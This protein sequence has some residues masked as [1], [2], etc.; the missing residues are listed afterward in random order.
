[1]MK[2]QLRIF[3]TSKVISE[4]SHEGTPLR[5]WKVQLRSMN[6]S[7]HY[8]ESLIDHVEYRLHPSFKESCIIRVHEPYRIERTGWGEFDM[9]MLLYFRDQTIPPKSITFDLHFKRP[10]YSIQKTLDIPCQKTRPS[11]VNES[12]QRMPQADTWSPSVLYLDPF[13]ESMNIQQIK[14]D[15]NLSHLSHI[16]KSL[17]DQDLRAFYQ[18]LSEFDLH[19]LEIMETEDEVI[20]N[21][22]KFEPSELLIVWKFVMNLKQY[23][24]TLLLQHLLHKGPCSH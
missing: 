10:K 6:T 3:C 8:L 14:N 1:M 12:T 13:H 5:S 20:L 18:L 2:I 22:N 4:T 11:T 15:M 24:E 7:P 9:L 19:H 17:N 21:L 23:K 16:L